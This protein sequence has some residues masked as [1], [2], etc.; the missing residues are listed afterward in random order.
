MRPQRQLRLGL[1]LPGL[2]RS[3]AAPRSPVLDTL[4]LSRNLLKGQKSHKLGAVCKTLGVSLKN[5][6]RAV[7]DA[8]ATAQALMIM[9]ERV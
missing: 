4:A 8:R 2:R 1:Y 5:A 7:H 6:H 3:G 9:L